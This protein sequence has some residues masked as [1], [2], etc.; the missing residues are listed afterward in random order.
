[1]QCFLRNKASD[2]IL[3]LS[4]LCCSL[5]MAFQAKRC[6]KLYSSQEATDILIDDN[7]DELIR[8]L[9]VQVRFPLQCLAG[10]ISVKLQATPLI[11][12]L[13]SLLCI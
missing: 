1:M 12:F 8:Q 5:S 11:S 2:I 10:P 4:L 6:N 3:I 9:K 13:Y 7:S